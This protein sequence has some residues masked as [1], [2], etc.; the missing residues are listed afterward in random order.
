[1]TYTY[2]QPV[3]GVFP[4]LK[5]EVRFL[6]QDTIETVASV[7]DEEIV[8]LLGSYNNQIYITASQLAATIAMKYGKE[9]AVT[10]RSVG[11]LSISVQYS[12]TAKF[13]QT[14]ADKLK[15]GKQD[16]SAVTYFINTPSQFEIGQFDELVP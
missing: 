9:A 3:A 14:L 10:S 8:Y 1:M 2:T 7:S 6:A 12:E 16:N 11:D 4:T 13:Y 5:D 15:L